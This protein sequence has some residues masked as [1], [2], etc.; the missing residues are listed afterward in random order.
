MSRRK[1]VPEFITLAML[2]RARPEP[3]CREQRA[4]F[5]ATFPDGMEVTEAN[6]LHAAKAGFSL[7]WAARQFL[8]A[9]IYADYNAK[10]ALIYADYRA[11]WALIRADYNAKRAPIYADYRAK[12]APIQADYNA[13]LAPI[14]WAI[15]AEARAVQT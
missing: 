12:M 14:L 11:K 1:T 15:I 7:D 13:K 5:A 3:A 6:L 4:L 2:R 8:P 9:L 10:R